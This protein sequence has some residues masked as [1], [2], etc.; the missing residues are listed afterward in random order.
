MAVGVYTQQDDQLERDIEAA[1]QRLVS[2]E[3]RSARVAAFESMKFLIAQRT[4]ERIAELERA[5]GL[6]V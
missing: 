6:C 2:T 1:Y 5:K 3:L 4:P